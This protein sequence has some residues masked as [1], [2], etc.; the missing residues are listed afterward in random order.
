MELRN[1]GTVKLIGQ[2]DMFLGAVEK[3]TIPNL[4]GNAQITAGHDGKITL[5]DVPKPNDWERNNIIVLE[6]GANQVRIYMDVVKKDAPVIYSI[7]TR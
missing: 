7:R 5:K 4:R 2:T 1:P 6:R 3:L